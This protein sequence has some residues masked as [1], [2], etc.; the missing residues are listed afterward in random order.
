MPEIVHIPPPATARGA[1]P[2]SYGARVGD[3]LFVSG[4]PGWDEEG[5]LSPDFATQFRHVVR[6]LDGVLA[7]AGA[8]RRRI[9]KANVFLTREED[10][11]TMNAL[12][13]E[14]F[15]PAPYPARITVV[16]RALPNPA[17]LIEIECVAALR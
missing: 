12:Y 16:V 17:M 8:D 7:A 1:P 11:A 9:A 6:A 2:L 13:A 10:V 5:R 15:G 14:A 3:L 4:L